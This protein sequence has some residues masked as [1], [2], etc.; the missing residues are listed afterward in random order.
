MIELQK[1]L[2]TSLLLLMIIFSSLKNSIVL[3]FVF[4]AI[5]YFSL[6]EINNL[7]KSIF[8]KKN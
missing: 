8:K 5:N 3:F 4:L 2:L 7:F 1:R 6:I